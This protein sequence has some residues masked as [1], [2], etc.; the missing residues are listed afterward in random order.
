VLALVDGVF[1]VDGGAGQSAFAEEHASVSKSRPCASSVILTHHVLMLFLWVSTVF[2]HVDPSNDA[3]QLQE[4][5]NQAHTYSELGQA[6]SGVDRSE[7]DLD[8]D[9]S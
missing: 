5:R 9:G 1:G 3:H 4:D 7:E 6:G 8:L 2:R